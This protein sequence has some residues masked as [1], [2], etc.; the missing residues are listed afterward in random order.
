VTN[1]V[2]VR[3]LRDY[4][5]HDDTCQLGSDALGNPRSCTCGLDAALSAPVAVPQQ[6]ISPIERLGKL[7]QEAG[8]TLKIGLRAQ[9]KFETVKEMYLAGE[10]WEDIGSAIGWSP[11]AA[12]EWYFHELDQSLNAVAVPQH[13]QEKDHQWLVEWLRSLA[14]RLE[15]ENAADRHE[16][17]KYGDI[18]RYAKGRLMQQRENLRQAAKAIEEMIATERS[19]SSGSLQSAAQESNSQTDSLPHPLPETVERRTIHGGN[20]ASGTP[21]YLQPGQCEPE[22][23]QGHSVIVWYDDL[24]DLGERVRKAESLL[25][26]GPAPSSALPQQAEVCTDGYCSICGAIALMGSNRCEKHE[27]SALPVIEQEESKPLRALSQPQLRA[28]ESDQRGDD[29]G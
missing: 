28:C 19:E 2:K 18:D 1:E 4:A 22:Y 7:L 14:H 20:V 15:S 21:F 23:D 12:Q 25:A 27:S 11:D 24:Y 29:R 26:H 13:E 5:K 16:H 8:A 6:I 9:G 10:S 17:G 3:T